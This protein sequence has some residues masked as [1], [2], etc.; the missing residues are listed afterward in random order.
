MD[1]ECHI[2]RGVVSVHE[3]DDLLLED[4]GDHRVIMHRQ[5]AAGFGL[6]RELHGGDESMEV[7]CPECGVVET[8]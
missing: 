5:C 2:C 4:H 7:T 1:N 6:V 8:L 3:P